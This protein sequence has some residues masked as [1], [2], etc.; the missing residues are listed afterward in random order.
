MSDRVPYSGADVGK[1]GAVRY[2]KLGRLGAATA[3]AGRALLVEDEDDDEGDV[4]AEA[5]GGRGGLS[6]W[7]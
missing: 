7:S 1:A 4:L 6:S 3:A 2:R 5:A